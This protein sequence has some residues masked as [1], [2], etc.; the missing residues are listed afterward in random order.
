MAPVGTPAYIAVARVAREREGAYSAP[1]AMAVGTAPPMPRPA[2]KRKE[3][4]LPHTRD[5]RAEHGKHAESE[6]AGNEHPLASDPVRKHAQKGRAEERSEL[7]GTDCHAEG[8][9]LDMQEFGDLGH[10]HA[11][12]RQ[13]EA[14]EERATKTEHGHQYLIGGERTEIENFRDAY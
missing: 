2:M 5:E 11:D 4:Q 1:K 12:D 8:L 10:R 13:I 3:R 7:P 14:V 6:G 9:G